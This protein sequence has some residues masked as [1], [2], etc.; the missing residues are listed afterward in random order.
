MNDGICQAKAEMT[1]RGMEESELDLFVWVLLIEAVSS[2]SWSMK[3]K[4][5][6]HIMWGD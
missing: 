4:S 6:M 2:E 5:N 1:S 3:Q